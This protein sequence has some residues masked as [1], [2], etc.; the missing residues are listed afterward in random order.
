MTWVEAM[1]RAWVVFSM[2]R[3]SSLDT[4]VAAPIEP[5]V[6]VMCLL[7]YFILAVVCFQVITGETYQPTS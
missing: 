5:V 6:D 3:L 1:P 4:A 2:E 7:F